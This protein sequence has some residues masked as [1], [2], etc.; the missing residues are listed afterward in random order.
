MEGVCQRGG[1]C[2]DVKGHQELGG[3]GEKI[4][5]ASAPSCPVP[6]LPESFGKT[7]KLW[8]SRKRYLVMKRVFQAMCLVLT[9]QSNNFEILVFD[10]TNKFRFFNVFQVFE[11]WGTGRIQLWFYNSIFIVVTST[12]RRQLGDNRLT[13]CQVQKL[14][15]DS[16][17]SINLSFYL[18]LLPV[19]CH[20]FLVSSNQK[21]IKRTFSTQ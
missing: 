18:S 15:M 7:C 3:G 1:I 14:P 5:V 16:H 13:A 19:L 2:F 21:N 10:L 8:N 17:L 12:A 9:W 20:L 11:L 4:E 6:P